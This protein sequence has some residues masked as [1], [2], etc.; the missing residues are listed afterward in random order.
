MDSDVI[1]YWIKNVMTIER[2]YNVTSNEQ[3]EVIIE[4]MDYDLI[5]DCEFNNDY[6]KFRKVLLDYSS[7]FTGSFYTRE[8]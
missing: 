4:L 5:P 1:F 7:V 2:W 8:K 3:K 6:S